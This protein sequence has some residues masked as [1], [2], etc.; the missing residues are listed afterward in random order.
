M[1]KS[2]IQEVLGAALN[3]GKFV[4]NRLFVGGGWSELPPIPPVE[5]RLP[6]INRMYEHKGY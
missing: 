3:V 1:E 2:P 5:N 4:V 6:E